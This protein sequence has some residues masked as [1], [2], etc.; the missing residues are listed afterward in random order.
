MRKKKH[1]K[2]NKNMKKEKYKNAGRKSAG[3]VGC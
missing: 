1:K 3:G 2:K